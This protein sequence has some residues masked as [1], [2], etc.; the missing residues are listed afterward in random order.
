MHGPVGKLL[1][2]L[3]RFLFHKWEL[4]DK[5]DDFIVPEFS[6]KA[7]RFGTQEEKDPKQLAENIANALKEGVARVDAWFEECIKELEAE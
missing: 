7:K 3:R 1:C 2:Q 4:T 6:Y 5:P